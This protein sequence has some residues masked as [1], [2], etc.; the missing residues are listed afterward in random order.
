MFLPFLSKN[1]ISNSSS[2][3]DI[4]LD[5]DNL[6]SGLQVKFDRGRQTAFRKLA[7]D[8]APEECWLSWQEFELVLVDEIYGVAAGGEGDGKLGITLVELGTH[9]LV[10]QLQVF[11]LRLT[12]S[13]MV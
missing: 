8:I 9:P 11:H 10:E 7:L 4:I 2:S 3:L 5:K 1:S 13:D 6:C 12:G